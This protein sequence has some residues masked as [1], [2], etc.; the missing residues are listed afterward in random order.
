MLGPPHSQGLNF[1]NFSSQ[2]P[3]PNTSH[4]EV[5][6]NTFS[7]TQTRVQA[8]VTLVLFRARSTRN[9]SVFISPVP[10]SQFPVPHPHFCVLR[11]WH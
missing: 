10:S 4:S 2:F 1:A 7:D 8:L 5:C 6:I 11:R 3:I 9:I